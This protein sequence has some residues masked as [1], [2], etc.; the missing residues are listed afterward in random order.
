M[1]G[2]LPW[3]QFT[4]LLAIREATIVLWAMICPKRKFNLSTLSRHHNFCFIYFALCY[5]NAFFQR[6][7]NKKIPANASV[8]TETCPFTAQGFIIHATRVPYF[9]RFDKLHA[10]YAWRLTRHI[11]WHSIL[12]Y[13]SIIILFVA[14][15]LLIEYGRCIPSKYFYSLYASCLRRTHLCK[16]KKKK[17]WTM[18]RTVLSFNK[19]SE[20]EECKFINLLK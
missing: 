12:F 5:S 18:M 6:Q 10:S 16:M 15:I 4:E 7:L 2:D 8:R 9:F 13:D 19:I 11:G 14:G 1:E 20:P 3:L 17:K